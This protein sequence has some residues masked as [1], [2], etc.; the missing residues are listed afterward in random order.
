MLNKNFKTISVIIFSLGLIFSAN[1]VQATSSSFILST[2]QVRVGDVFVAELKLADLKQI[3][4]AMDGLIIFDPSFLQVQD[5]STGDSVFKLWPRTPDFSSIDGKIMFTGG[6]PNGTEG[7]SIVK[8]AFLAKK[9]GQ[10]NFY[11]SDNSILYLN[12]GQGTKTSAQNQK[13]SLTILEAEGNVP[14]QNTWQESLTSDKTAPRNL[15]IQLGQDPYTFDGQYFI[16]FFAEDKESGIDHYEV[17]EGDK[18]FVTT[19]SPYILSDQSLKSKIFVKAVDKNG[20][21][22]VLE[23]KNTKAFYLQSWFI[24]LVIILIIYFIWQKKKSNRK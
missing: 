20:N 5:V 19:A 21:E 1:F 6:V 17:K 12:D 15:I 22:K 2:S 11:L 18:D 3:I 7:G 10:A 24:S 4:N 9:A 23:F 16:S 14:A 8:I 13:V